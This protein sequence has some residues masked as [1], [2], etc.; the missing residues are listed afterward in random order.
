MNI[1]ISDG[2]VNSGLT[3]TNTNETNQNIFNCLLNTGNPSI[4][5]NIE[6]INSTS[7]E[8][9]EPDIYIQSSTAE[10]ISVTL[11][12]IINDTSTS[13]NTTSA[14]AAIIFTIPDNLPIGTY[15]FEVNEIFDSGISN[16]SSFSFLWHSN[17]TSLT[18]EDNEEI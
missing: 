10:S 5:S 11:F 16:T 4:G 6:A 13:I 14:G 12:D 18:N 1:E 9:P 15:T 8:F 7:A 17:T 2:A 3:L